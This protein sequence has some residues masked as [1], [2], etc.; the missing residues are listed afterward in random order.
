MTLNEFIE[1][2]LEIS[3]V[4]EK[5]YNIEVVCRDEHGEPYAPTVALLTYRDGVRRISV[6]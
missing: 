1:R 4:E 3:A 5:G 6:T 2:L